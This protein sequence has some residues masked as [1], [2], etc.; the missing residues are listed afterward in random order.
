MAMIILC[1]AL[2]TLQ[3]RHYCAYPLF[4]TACTLPQW[5]FAA[6]TKEACQQSAQPAVSTVQN[7]LCLKRP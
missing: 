6:S 7:A 1:Q 2:L 4:P 3:D 5:P